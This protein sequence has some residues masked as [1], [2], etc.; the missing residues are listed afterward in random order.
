MKEV[1][2]LI[3]DKMKELR[4]ILTDKCAVRHLSMAII[5]KD[6][7][8][9]TYFTFFSAQDKEHPEEISASVWVNQ[10]TGEEIY[11]EV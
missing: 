8:N 4:E 6:E 7:D 11:Y 1:E 10:I 5:E 2:R 9:Q 3:L